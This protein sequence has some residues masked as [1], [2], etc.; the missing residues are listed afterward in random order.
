MECDDSRI[1]TKLMEPKQVIS[2]L[3]AAF[4]SLC[5]CACGDRH[6]AQSFA[7]AATVEL[8]PIQLDKRDPE[9]TDFGQLKLLSAF[10]LRSGDARFGG[11]SGLAIGTDHRLYAVSDHGFWLSARMH[12]NPAGRLLDLTN[13]QIEP[14]LSTDGLPI[15]RRLIDAE[16]LA[17]EPDGSFLVGFEDPQR[18]WRY[19]A[20]P[21]TFSSPAEPVVI[22]REIMKAPKNGGLEALSSL[23]GGQIFAIAE[24]FE[25]RDRT[26][27]AWLLSHG[28]S[29]Q[30]SYQ[31]AV[32]FA[33]SDATALKNGDV[34]VL[35]RRYSPPLFFSVRLTRV[36]AQ[37]IRPGA[38]LR[39]EEL[40][41][42]EGGVRTE[43]FEGV[44]TI[45]KDAGTLIFL[46]SDDNYL[47]LQRT[48]LL[49]FF[50]PNS[51]TSAGAGA[52]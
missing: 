23:P 30:L 48:L 18:I 7:G 26:L 13:W 25:N 4:L 22:P 1:L 11:L 9:R 33:V 38:A 51:P 14:L 42:L 28:Q 2:S 8:S 35:E 6:I 52:H 10:E 50:L 3:I 16:A 43:N 37:H 32:N 24:D 31:P 19:R 34:L 5:A 29:A 46:I 41:R 44:A 12:L 47:P 17:R 45:E 21:E 40:L 49:Q 39:G 27:K 36:R 15:R 20:P